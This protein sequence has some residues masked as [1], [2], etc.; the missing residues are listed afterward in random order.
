MCQIQ[1]VPKFSIDK[2]IRH[3]SEYLLRKIKLVTASR[4]HRIFYRIPES[5]NSVILFKQPP[6]TKNNSLRTCI[7]NRKGSL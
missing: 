7:H 4:V 6:V 2:G 1:Y 5:A 3:I